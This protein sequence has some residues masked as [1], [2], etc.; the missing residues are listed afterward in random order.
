MRAFLVTCCF[1]SALGVVA[2]GA[3]APKP[4][5]PSIVMEKKMEY[6]QN[7]LRALM[8]DDFDEAGKNVKLM[9]TFTHLEEMFRGRRPGYE[10]QLKKFQ[11]SVA[12]LSQAIDEKNHDGSTRAYMGMIQTCIQCHKVLRE[13]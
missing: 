11:A 1:M 10:D 6:S 12:D 7:L 8:T 2:L 4:E 5:K 9:K 3:D 13:K